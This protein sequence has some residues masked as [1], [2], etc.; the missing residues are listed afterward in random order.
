MA[1]VVKELA[2]QVM[3][4]VKNLP[5]S[6]GDLRDMGSIPGFT[7]VF[8]PGESCRQRSLV[9]SPCGHRE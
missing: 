7:P 1:I 2:S 6:A 9:D 4:V 5:V 8:L 3:L